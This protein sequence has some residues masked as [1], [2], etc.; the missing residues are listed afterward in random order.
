MFTV[1]IM[2]DCP[3]CHIRRQSVIVEARGLEEDVLEFVKRA[4]EAAGLDH[5]MRSPHC[6]SPHCALMLPATGAR[7]GDPPLQ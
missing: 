4:G 6:P 5:T 1:T 3:G 7:I 2:Y